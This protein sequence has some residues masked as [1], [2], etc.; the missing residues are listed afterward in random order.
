MQK[1]VRLE[2]RRTNSIK[3]YGFNQI[4]SLI[5]G[6]GERPFASTTKDYGFNQIGSLI[7]DR[8]ERTF[9]PTTEEAR[10]CPPSNSA[11]HSEKLHSGK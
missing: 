3:H 4:G 11:L 7:A 1:L 2:K 9:A 10:M 6:G 8:G 5:A